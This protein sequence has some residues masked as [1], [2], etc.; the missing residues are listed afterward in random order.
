MAL[1]K[2]GTYVLYKEF[3]TDQP[4]HPGFIYPDDFA[5][6]DVQKTRPNG[7]VTLLLLLNEPYE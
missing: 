6:L 4:S 2:P 5:P 1:T 3:G 7:Y